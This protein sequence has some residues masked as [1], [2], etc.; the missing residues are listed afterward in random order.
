MIDKGTLDAILSAR[1]GPSHDLDPA[2]KYIGELTRVLKASGLLLLISNM[3]KDVLLHALHLCTRRT[4]PSSHPAYQLAVRSSVTCQSDAG[5]T[6]FYHT[7]AK[8]RSDSAVASEG[9]QSPPELCL[10][11]LLSSLQ[12]ESAVLVD[13]QGTDPRLSPVHRSPCTF[14]TPTAVTL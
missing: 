14:K 13:E 2:I 1:A 4:Q 5:N 12:K 10:Q 8:V 11:Q 9:S 6:V 7:L 3:P